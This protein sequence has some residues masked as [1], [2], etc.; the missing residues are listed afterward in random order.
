MLSVALSNF[1]LS[2]INIDVGVLTK[3]SSSASIE[4]TINN[5]RIINCNQSGLLGIRP[6]RNLKK[7]K[8]RDFKM[9]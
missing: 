4:R 1:T 3:L 6:A 9:E 7:K 8:F 5:K 2:L